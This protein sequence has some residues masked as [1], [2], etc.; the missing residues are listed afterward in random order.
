MSINKKRSLFITNIIF[1]LA[2]FFIASAQ[3]NT[4]NHILNL[5]EQII[6]LERQSAEYKKQINQKKKKQTTLK[7][8][9]SILENQISRLRVNILSTGRKIDLAGLE[10]KDLGRGISETEKKINKN[11]ETISELLRRLNLAEKHDLAAVLLSNARISDFFGYIER[12][13]SLQTELSANLSAFL[14]LKNQLTAKKEST[15]NKK[16]ELKILNRR[17]ENQKTASVETQT[18]KS[19]LLEKTKG[20]EKIF[21]EL[22]SEAE[23]KKAQFYEELKKLESEARAEGLYI[24]RVKAESIP[25]KGTKLFK[26]PLED[27]IIT[28]GF[29]MTLFAKR[30]AYGGAPHN[31]IDL[32]A[33][34]GSEIKSIGQGSVLAKGFNNA[35]GNWIAIRHDN[36][37]VSVY[38]HMRDPTLI[39]A[40]ERVNEKTV[41]GYEGATGFATGS[42]LHLS[43]YYE[44]F[45][46]IGP[47]TGQIYFNY[48]Q[49]SLNPL[50]YI[51]D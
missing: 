18:A 13:N 10:I 43:L 48:W 3:E 8:E 1:F 32:R 33:G 25:P 26:M 7:R 9:I 28:Q 34:P 36:D 23:K 15:E 27:Y 6:E 49:G 14:D 21:Q 17:Q 31:G 42:H 41:L 39:L 37:L 30:G 29:G 51:S 22:L 45:S 40:G 50:D 24:V 38:G 44:F 19:G 4:S 35:A 20:Q 2:G 46:F 11:R 5:R 12:V 47:K 16:Q